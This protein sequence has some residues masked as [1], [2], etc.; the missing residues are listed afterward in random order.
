[1]PSSTQAGTG[2]LKRPA[3]KNPGRTTRKAPP[4]TRATRPDPSPTPADLLWR[5]CY[6]YLKHR[7]QATIICLAKPQCTKIL[8]VNGPSPLH[9][10]APTRR[11]LAPALLGLTTVTL[12]WWTPVVEL[13][14][15][16]TRPCIMT[17]IFLALRSR[18]T[19]IR[20]LP[21]VTKIPIFWVVEN[22][23]LLSTM[24]ASSHDNWDI[25]ICTASSLPDTVY[26]KCV[27][28]A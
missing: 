7:M 2:M 24:E 12:G 19:C 27:D 28:M 11:L 16:T 14:P 22:R 17:S 3:A 23:T 20:K 21:R 15:F 13:K 6:S 4:P 8:L 18:S 26:G 10:R 5:G 1:M 25:V 9:R